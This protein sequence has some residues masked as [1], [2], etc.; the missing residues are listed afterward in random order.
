MRWGAEGRFS[1]TPTETRLRARRE[2]VV[3]LEAYPA[4]AG[5]QEG[6]ARVETGLEG[7]V[8]REV[9]EGEGGE[10]LCT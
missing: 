2:V 5:V 6:G 9:R 10:A 7:R 3:Q 1:H 4:A 8:R